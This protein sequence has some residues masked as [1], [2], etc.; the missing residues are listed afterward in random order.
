MTIRGVVNK[1]NQSELDGNRL[2]EVGGVRIV[3]VSRCSFAMGICGP[4]RR[5]SFASGASSFPF[6]FPQK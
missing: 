4:P 3:M 5:V 2:S 1:L 6:T